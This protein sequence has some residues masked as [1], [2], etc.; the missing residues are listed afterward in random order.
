MLNFGREIFFCIPS[1]PRPVRLVDTMLVSLRH[2][3]CFR[4]LRSKDALYF[5]RVR[6]QLTIPRHLLDILWSATATV[7]KAS[8]VQQEL[9]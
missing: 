1:L 5:L 3:V 4:V 7:P 6:Y 2:F 8:A 9:R